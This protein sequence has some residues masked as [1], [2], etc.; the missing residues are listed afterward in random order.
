MP[1][2]GMLYGR[3]GTQV[4]PDGWAA[5]LA[6]VVN[7][8]HTVPATLRHPGTVESWD[9][10]SQ[11]MGHTPLAAYWTGRARFQALV[12]GGRRRDTPTD[13]GDAVHITNYL[14][15]LPLDVVDVKPGDLVTVGGP[16]GDPALEG[17][18]LLIKDVTDGELELE[19]V[20][21]GYLT[22]DT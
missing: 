16:P 3:P 10:A 15:A 21:Y 22:D 20:C 6:P 12:G 18:T 1:R 17:R 4:I 9:E 14:V 13:S 19:R 7:G 8:T 5:N 11:Q 2:R